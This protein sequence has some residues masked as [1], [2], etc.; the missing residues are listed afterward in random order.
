MIRR[1]PRSTLFPYTTLFRSDV[2][3][4]G[5]VIDESRYASEDQPA[6]AGVRLLAEQHGEVVRADRPPVRQRVRPRPAGRPVVGLGDAVGG[7]GLGVLERRGVE[8]RDLILE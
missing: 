3:G 6:C 2:A 5:I 7:V 1:P 4:G 8:D